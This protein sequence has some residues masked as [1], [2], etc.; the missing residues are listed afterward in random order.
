M[1]PLVPLATVVVIQWHHCCQ[2]RQW[3]IIDA[4]FTIVAIVDIGVPSMSNGTNGGNG[5]IGRYWRHWM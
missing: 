4:I 3:I 1:V 5:N 2:Y